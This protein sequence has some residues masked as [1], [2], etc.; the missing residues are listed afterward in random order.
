MEANN[1][2]TNEDQCPL[3]GSELSKIKLREIEAKLRSDGQKQAAE[4][5]KAGMAE[6][7][8]LEQQFKLDLE[9]QKQAIE[10]KLK[11]E[12]DQQLKLIAIERDQ[13]ARKLKAAEEREA[14][15]R[16]EA[17]VEIAKQKQAAEKKANDEADSK[18]KKIVIERD[19][20]AKKLKEAQDRE[21][22]AIKQTQKDAEKQRQKELDEQRQVLDKDKTL[23]L[24]KQAAIFNREREGLQKKMQLMDKQLQKKTANELGDGAEIDL[25][26]ALRESFSGL[27]DQIRRIRKG[28]PGADIVHEVFYKAQS[29]GKIILDS[30]NHQDWKSRFVSKLRK[31][32]VE[33]GAQHAILTTAAFPKGKKEMCIESDVIVMAPARVVYVVQ[34]LRQAMVTMHV[35]GLSNRERTTKMSKL[36]ELITSE[37]YAGKF[38]EANKLTQDILDLEVQERTTHN[39]VWIKRGS[40]LKRIQNVLSDTQTEVSAIIESNGEVASRAFPAK[41]IGDSQAGGGTIEEIAAWSKR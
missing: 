20:F 34:I 17:T 19:Q 23:S 40:F 21:A 22:E 5:A 28:Q 15:V 41:S 24:L 2:R 18:I 36:Y 13:A 9:K 11:Q 25:F 1:V 32:Q 39:N 6:K 35:R 14:A 38:A 7:Q 4:I 29:C 33:E 26:E 30:K 12:S 27:G 10:K 37:S 3:C 8:R 16:K 31:D